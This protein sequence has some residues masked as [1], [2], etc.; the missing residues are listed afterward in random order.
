MHTLPR[1]YLQ[2]HVHVHVD[3][4][5]LSHLHTYLQESPFG[6]LWYSMM[7]IIVYTVGG[8]DNIMLDLDDEWSNDYFLFPVVSYILWIV[9]IVAM[10]VLFL[11]LLVPLYSHNHSCLI[12]HARG[13]LIFFLT[14]VLCTHTCSHIHMY[15]YMLDAFIY[16]HVC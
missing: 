15:S 12:P 9:F 13:V 3:E 14:I 6:S 2:A 1:V 8:P 10:S 11:N 16:I 5:S 4:Y 7:T